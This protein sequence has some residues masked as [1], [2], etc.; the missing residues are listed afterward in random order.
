[1]TDVP[2]P[3]H[4]LYRLHLKTGTEKRAEMI[5]YCLAENLIGL[6]WGMHHGG[7]RFDAPRDFS[8]WFSYASQIWPKQRT[9]KFWPVIWMHDADEGSL[10][11][12]RDLHNIYYLGQI[13][14]EWRYLD[15]PLNRDLDLTSVRRVNYVRIGSEAEVPGAV[16][17]S[18][19]KPQSRAFEHVPDPSAAW[20]SSFIFAEKGGVT[21]P[22]WSPTLMQVI[23][24]LLGTLDV[25]DLIAAYLQ[26][27]YH[28]IALPARYSD[29]TAAYEWVL[30]DPA[31]GDLAVAQ[32]KTGDRWVDPDALPTP[33]DNLLCFVFSPRGNI[34]SD[35]PSN[36]RALEVQD[37]V[38]FMRDHPKALPPVAQ[39]WAR[40]AAP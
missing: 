19:S 10:V 39:R 16:V 3:P 25:Q 5:N 34:P 40:L 27:H 6:G 29:S 38:A 2:P 22:A 4:S 9:W 13:V 23:D 35:L 33:E 24:S 7:G 31:T 32:V 14:G 30:Q 18:F 1:M 37:V 20:Y 28:Y 17:R 8:E 11:W 36:V 15:T 26:V 21:P 12:T